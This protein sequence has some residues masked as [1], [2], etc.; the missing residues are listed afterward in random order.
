MPARLDKNSKPKM[1]P[2]ILTRDEDLLTQSVTKWMGFMN[3]LW[4]LVNIKLEN[5]SRWNAAWGT[6]FRL[7]IILLSS[8]VTVMADLDQVPR[9][10]VT[11]VAGVMT[12]LTGME[13]FLKFNERQLEARR[14]QR[15]IEALR[16]ELRFE[17]FARVEVEGDMKKRLKAARILLQSGPKD[18]NEI[19]NK[20]VLKAEKGDAPS[21][22]H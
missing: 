14:Q 20:Y 16:D 10:V 3:N 21:V 7:L 18:Y 5:Q 13:A 15:E 22:N 9:S 2:R 17:W 1:S 12:A 8:S 4:S 19:L 6:T 11:I